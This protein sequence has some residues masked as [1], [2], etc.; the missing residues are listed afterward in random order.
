MGSSITDLRYATGTVPDF[1]EEEPPRSES[2]E[3]VWIK[4]EP[5]DDEFGFHQELNPLW[6]NNFQ[7][8]Q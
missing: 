5:S 4:P 8:N 3:E 7:A 6:G 2:E 1:M